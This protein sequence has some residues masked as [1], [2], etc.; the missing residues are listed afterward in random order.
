MQDWFRPLP[1][2]ATSAATA[3]G[4]IEQ[5]ARYLLLL[6]AFTIPF[7]TALSNLFVG[8]T[9]IAF[10]L[11][12]AFDRTLARP[13]LTPAPLLA[14]ALL[15]LAIIGMAWS[16]A[17]SDAMWTG[18][19]K[20]FK[21][22]VLPLAVCLC[23]RAP[24]LPARVLRWSLAG[25]LFLAT[26]LY[27]V[28]LGMMPTSSLG[29]WRVGDPS[30][31]Y[32]FRNHI[33]YGILLSF[34][35]CACFLLATWHRDARARLAALAA[36]IYFCAP[37]L[38]GNGRTG[39]VGLFVGL[40]ALFLLRARVT[41]ARTLAAGTAIMLMFGAVYMVSPNV[42]MRMDLMVVEIQ[43]QDPT[44]PNGLRMSYIKTG[45][46]AVALR[47]LFGY[48]TG[49]FSE[50]Y[51]TQ[52]YR[53]GNASPDAMTVRHQPHSEPLLLA[54]QFG[55]AGVVLYFG[56]LGTIGQAALAR[57]DVRYDALARRDVGYDT[58][59]LLVVIYGV[60]STFNSLLW[61]PAEAYW[62]LLLAGA[63]YAHC[64]QGRSTAQ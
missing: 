42:K 7:S 54:V 19:R 32:V 28:W 5:V 31:A 10:L 61:N 23:W 58:L 9:L 55:L 51:A 11:A 26:S 48:G 16:I 27:L 36:G 24:A 4:R 39:Y 62:F 49:S 35:A 38:M 6:A 18:I 15:A 1:V 21:L 50:V 34:A 64:V 33:T 52:A 47:P 60:T 29:W 17:P 56:L 63:L 59:A 8:L 44:T 25:C 40:F 45:I 14:L 46:H 57:R 13:L 37:I 22:V 3:P 30:D 41:V 43:T 12:L 2:S 53:V 20:Y